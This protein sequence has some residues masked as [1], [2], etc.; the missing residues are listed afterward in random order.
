[1]DLIINL[2]GNNNGNPGG[3]ELSS[4]G[5]GKVDKWRTGLDSIQSVNLH[6]SETPITSMAFGS[7]DNSTLDKLVDPDDSASQIS[8]IINL[9]HLLIKLIL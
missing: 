7:P 2:L 5:Y 3:S 9:I 8:E 4:I 6:D 1:M